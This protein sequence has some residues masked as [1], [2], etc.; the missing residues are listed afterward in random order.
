MVSEQNLCVSCYDTI[1]NPVCEACHQ[2]EVSIWLKDV[3][4]DSKTSKHII[5]EIKESMP[6]EAM[7]ENICI[8]CGRNTLSTCSYCFF[9]ASAKVLKKLH[10]DHKLI[11]YFL[12]SFNYRMGHAEYVL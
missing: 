12:Q 6:E 5:E 9:L 4:I 8:L 10:I 7:N 2:R 1:T 11:E 3:G